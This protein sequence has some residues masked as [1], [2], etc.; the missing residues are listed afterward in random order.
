MS[1]LFKWGGRKAEDASAASA[2]VATPVTSDTLTTSKVLPT[3]SG[4]AGARASAGP[5][6]S[7]SGRRHQHLV[8]R[9]AARVQDLR[10]RSL[11]RHREPRARRATR[12]QLA[13][14]LARRVSRTRPTRSTASC[15]GTC[16]T[17]SI[18]RPGRP[19]AA[20]ARASCCARAASLYGFFGTTPVDLTHYTRFVVEADDTL[21]LRPVSGHA[22]ASAT[23]CSRATSTRC[24]T[25]STVA[26]SV[27]LKT[28]HPRDAVP[29][30]VDAST[31]AG[32][33]SQ[34]GRLRHGEAPHCLP[35]RFRHPRPLRRRDEG[36]GAGDHAR[37]SRSSTSRT[38]CRRTT[39]RSPRTSWRRPT[40]TFPPGT[41][42]LVVVDPG[43]GHAAPRAWRPRPA[44]GGSSRPTTAC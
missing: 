37:T 9:R 39:S 21:R 17:F 31:A 23:C 22:R 8:L 16:S 24:S 43:V 1:G 30:A 35:Q 26:E 28:Q 18:G 40:S 2:A 27:L 5:A 41:I 33:E 15:A 4:G 11:R 6:R 32:P 29:Q 19:L 7:R 10:R 38:T 14:R 42:F 44:T 20:Q 36:R 25:G 34:P 12:D 3:L 13:H